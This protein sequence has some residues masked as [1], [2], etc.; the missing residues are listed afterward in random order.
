[1]GGPEEG[2][3]EQTEELICCADAGSECDGVPRVFGHAAL[4]VWAVHRPE[5]S[6]NPTRVAA[7]V[8]VL[9]IR[10]NAVN[11]LTPLL[12]LTV[13]ELPTSSQPRQREKDHGSP[14]HASE[15]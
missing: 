6:D 1:M 4:A 10:P 9:Q 5:K 11:I 7:G 12:S 2:E 8:R 3:K 14:Y 13:V 15:Q